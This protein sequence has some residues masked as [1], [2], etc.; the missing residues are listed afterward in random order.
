MSFVLVLQKDMTED[1]DLPKRSSIILLKGKYFIMFQFAQA[2][3][4]YA[5]LQ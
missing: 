3:R 1:S 2:N 5:L 4:E